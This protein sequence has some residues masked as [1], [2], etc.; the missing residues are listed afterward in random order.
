MAT[1]AEKYDLFIILTSTIEQY[2]QDV[3]LVRLLHDFIGE[4]DYS[5]NALD[6]LDQ[7]L[8]QISDKSHFWH[9]LKALTALYRAETEAD[10]QFLTVGHKVAG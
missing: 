4:G 2:C 6:A 7:E 3:K 10:R 8:S 9:V 1:Q 5:D